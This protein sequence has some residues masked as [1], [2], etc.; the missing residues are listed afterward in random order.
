MVC[1]VLLWRK[2]EEMG[3]A[4][5]ARERV[6]GR[7]GVKR[8]AGNVGLGWKYCVGEK[9]VVGEPTRESRRET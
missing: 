1:G 3:V 4:E 8:N 6:D 7:Q 2:W 9:R 5:R